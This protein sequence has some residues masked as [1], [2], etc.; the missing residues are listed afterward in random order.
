MKR[1][2]GII[3][4]MFVPMIYFGHVIDSNMGER[5]RIQLAQ[6]P[7]PKKCGTELFAAPLRQ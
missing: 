6:Y 4:D 1:K 7:L 2:V 5:E 3:L